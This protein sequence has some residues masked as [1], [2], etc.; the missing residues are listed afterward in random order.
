M[1][2]RPFQFAI[3]MT[4]LAM[5]APQAAWADSLPCLIKHVGN[6]APWTVIKNCPVEAG[7]VK[8]FEKEPR[9]TRMGNVDTPEFAD[10]KETIRNW[11]ELKEAGDTFTFKKDKKYWMVFYPKDTVVA[12][13]LDFVKGKATNMT[14]LTVNGFFH[15]GEWRK[16]SGI[17]SIAKAPPQ[18]ALAYGAGADRK[19]ERIQQREFRQGPRSRG[20][21]RERL[22]HPAL[23][24]ISAIPCRPWALPCPKAPAARPWPGR[25]SRSRR[26]R[27]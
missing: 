22:P 7:K 11:T 27:W 23:S 14:T 2:T 24:P 6:L 10:K 15:N 8:V 3:V 21:A 13:R 20:Q 18:V 16:K 5:A 17:T 1:R 25:T 19:H 9:Y 4:G 12:V 26:D